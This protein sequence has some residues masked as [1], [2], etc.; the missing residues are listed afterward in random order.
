VLG[1][2][3]G[4]SGEADLLARFG[5][6]SHDD[7][8][9]VAAVDDLGLEEPGDAFM[10]ANADPEVLHAGHDREAVE[11]FGRD[12]QADIG[13]EEALPVARHRPG[14]GGHAAR[15]RGPGQVED[16]R[17]EGEP[18]GVG[19]ADEGVGRFHPDEFI[20]LV[21]RRAGRGRREQVDA[22]G[23]AG[24]L[25]H[26]NPQRG[27]GEPD[28]RVGRVEAQVPEGIEHR[29]AQ[30]RH[31]DPQGR[32]V[33][34]DPPAVVHGAA[35]TGE[36]QAQLDRHPGVRELD[37]GARRAA[38]AAEAARPRVEGQRPGE[39]LGRGIGRPRPVGF[40]GLDRAGAGQ[41]VEQR[42]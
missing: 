10:D 32:G 15:A 9:G 42:T 30:E 31:P 1:E 13:Q 24:E 39:V 2:L 3:R 35:G 11:P 4:V 14:A 22:D 16:R 17:A 7:R 36:V 34:D 8:G 21:D 5:D 20:D 29:A 41:P 33:Q 27:Q 23:C 25:L 26:P 12:E 40:G 28:D 6:E 37:R 19:R 38:G 18:D